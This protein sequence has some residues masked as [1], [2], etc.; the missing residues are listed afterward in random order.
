LEGTYDP[1]C[2]TFDE[3]VYDGQGDQLMCMLRKEQR[4]TGQSELIDGL[5]VDEEVVHLPHIYR[6]LR[7]Q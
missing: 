1:T 4:R 2:Q 6:D 5:F 7:N 3:Y